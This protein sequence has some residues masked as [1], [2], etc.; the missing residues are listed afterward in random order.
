MDVDFEFT[1]TRL[2]KI[3]NASRSGRKAIHSLSG[4]QVLTQKGADDWDRHDS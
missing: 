2:A 4:L 3:A 1:V